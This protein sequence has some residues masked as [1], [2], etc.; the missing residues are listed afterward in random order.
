MK[1]M[2]AI[3]LI[4]ISSSLFAVNVT[5]RVNSSTVEG[6]VDTTSGVDLRGTV[7]QWGPGTNMTSDGGDYWSLTIALDAGDYEYKY[8]AQILNLD[9]TISDYWENDIPGANYV[10]NNRSLTVGTEDMTIDLDYLGSGPDG[11]GSY[12]PTD[13]I[14]VLFR[15]NMSEHPDFDPATQSV[16]IAGSLQ[17]WDP[18]S[19]PL[20]REGTSD[21][22]SA[23]LVVEAGA[24]EWKFTLGA[25]GTDE[26]NNRGPVTISQDTTIQWVYWNDQGPL[27]FTPTG[28]LETFSLNTSVANA[29]ASNGFELGDTLLVKYGYGGTQTVAMEDTLTNSVGNL[30]SVTLDSMPFDA[31]AGLYY[32]YYRVKNGVQYREI[33]FNFAYTG[34]DQTLAERRFTPLAGATDGGTLALDDNVSSNVDERRMPVFRNTDPIGTE[35]IVTYTVDVRPAYYQI[36]SGD[37]LGDIQGSINI[38]NVDQIATLGIS[39]NGPA[40]G[41]WTTWGATLNGTTTNTMHDDGATGGD[42]VAGDSIYS[43]QFTHPATATIGQE[44]K[45][46]IGGGD[47]ES[48]YGL[49]HIDNIDIANAS[50]ASYWGSINPNKYDAWNFDTN[51][52]T[53]A[54]DEVHNGLT[55]KRFSLSDNYPN[56]FN[57]TTSFS[58]SL[59]QGADVSINIYNLLGKKVASVFNDYAKPGTY[60]ATWD[61]KDINGASLPSGLY[62]YELDAGIY[63]KQTKKMTLV[64]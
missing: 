3:S 14:D 29:V 36:A 35:T 47:N 33:Y 53:L 64:K 56:P 7:T 13:G 27:P 44:F 10:G 16:Y 34:D 1:K 22:W 45:F 17:G 12:T 42:L 6:I 2:L 8:G 28:T 25:W 37:S 46:G 40:T 63:F 4:I 41:G 50:V 9:G 32:Q 26:S 18:G 5:F 54:I 20:T 52:P 61:G 19:S 60:T 59:P 21:Y 24:H 49:N 43:V 55:P 38:T 31:A 23:A 62:I 58:F 57:P 51:T 11:S 39:M 30:Y 48:G 15:V